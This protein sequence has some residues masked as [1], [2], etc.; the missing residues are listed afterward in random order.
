M[1]ALG[2]DAAPRSWIAD[3]LATAPGPLVLVTVGL[4]YLGLAQVVMALNDPVVHGASMWPA[5]GLS[6]GVLMLLPTK[7]WGWAIGAVALAL[8]SMRD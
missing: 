3:R 5:A 8:E 6:L 2:T 4:A 7:S 1:P